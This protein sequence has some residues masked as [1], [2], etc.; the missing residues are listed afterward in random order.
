[1]EK[2]VQPLERRK[3]IDVSVC[4]FE[5]IDEKSR[6]LPARNLAARDFL[7]EW[8]HIPSIRDGK[9]EFLLHVT[10]VGVWFSMASVLFR[11]SLL[12]KVGLFRTDRKSFADV[13]W[14]MLACLYTDIAW[15]PGKWSTFRVSTTQATPSSGWGDCKMYW[16][17]IKQ[18]I[19]DGPIPEQWKKLPG[20]ESKL[21]DV[22]DRLHRVQLHSLDCYR[23]V[24]RS[25][26]PRFVRGVKKAWSEEPLWLLG[27]AL[28]G[29]P[30]RGYPT[31]DDMEKFDLPADTHELIKF[32]GTKWP[33]EKVTQW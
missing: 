14:S 2:L 16:H 6:P 25:D 21:L 27:Q 31:T 15:V 10:T 17:A 26:W 24:A 11:R 1:L 32:F 3:N 18:V 7:G 30:L 5:E 12:D 9:T 33:P 13:E 4:D 20:W 23:W 8:M 29:F 19:D 28:R 22:R